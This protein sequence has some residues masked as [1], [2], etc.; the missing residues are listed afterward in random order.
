MIAILIH[1][2]NVWDG[3]RRTVG[4]L[5]PYFEEQGIPCVMIRYGW[6]GI[7][8]TYLKNWKVAKRVSEACDVASLAG[9]EVIVVGHSNGCAIAHR[10]ASVHGTKIK[11]MVYINP[12]LE[13]DAELPRSVEALDVWYSPS[14]KPVKWSKWLPLHPWGEMGATGYKGPFDP[15]VNSFN[16][17]DDFALSSKTHSDVF[18]WFL[19]KYFGS[20]IA[21]MA[22]GVSLFKE[23]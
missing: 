6:F 17:E 16:K 18:A 15:R 13:K 11:K 3:G 23:G 7:G 2:F 21:R 12:A 22:S 10:A 19:I 14:D 1:G 9:S 4:K 20:L 5:K 8:S